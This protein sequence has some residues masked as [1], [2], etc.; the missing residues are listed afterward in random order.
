EGAFAMA[1]KLHHSAV[2]G[3]A[4]V[5][6]IAALHDLA[7]DGP[8]PAGPESPWRPE[9]LPSNAELLRER[10]MA[11]ALPPVGVGAARAASPP[12]V[13]SGLAGLPGKLIGGVVSRV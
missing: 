13:L 9:P 3:M 1:L 7:A 6:T 10:E 2:D 8:R 12:Q 11:A 5:Q 4:S